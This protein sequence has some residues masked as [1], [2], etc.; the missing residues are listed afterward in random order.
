MPLYSYRCSACAHEFEALVS[1][2]D[3]PVCPSCGAATLERLISASVAVGGRSARLVRTAR[4]AA[5]REGHMSN[6]RRSEVPRK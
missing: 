6:Y 1:G 3:K 4:S 5:A 2:A